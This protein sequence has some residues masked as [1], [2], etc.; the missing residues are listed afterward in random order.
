[1]PSEIGR[2]YFGRR[3][4]RLRCIMRLFKIHTETHKKVVDE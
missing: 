3:I 4:I 1:M 2:I